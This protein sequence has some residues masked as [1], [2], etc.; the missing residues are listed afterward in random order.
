MKKS[1]SVIIVILLLLLVLSQ[2][3]PVFF[4]NNEELFKLPEITDEINLY[5]E[6]A[7]VIRDNYKDCIVME[8]SIKSYQYC[9]LAIENISIRNIDIKIGD[10]LYENNDLLEEFQLE[11][12]FRV[13]EVDLDSLN[14]ILNVKLLNLSLLRLEFYLK[15][16]NIEQVYLGQKIKYL[17]NYQE[18]E[19][20]ISL[21][22]PEIINGVVKVYGVLIEKPNVSMNGSLVNIEITTKLRENVLLV[23]R[24]AVYFVN[25]VSY[26]D[27]ITYRDNRDELIRTKV[28]LGLEN[29]IY[30]EILSGLKE[31]Q[32]VAI[33]HNEAKTNEVN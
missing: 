3:I 13:V 4:R 2:F 20:E 18:Y 22:E 12:N 30:Y 23:N 5:D 16:E 19:A 9:N 31:G 8:G 7:Y 15:Q 1:Y 14:D 29:S 21:I 10:Y 27:L 24:D 26:V 33:Y 17:F 6:S 32:K 11:G 25:E 28:I